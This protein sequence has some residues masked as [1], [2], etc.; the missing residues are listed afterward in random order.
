MNNVSFPALGIEDLAI[1]PVAFTIFGHEVMWYGIIITAA[2][3]LAVCYV[4]WR[5]RLEGVKK[6]DIYDL[7]IAV[8]FTG[9]VGARLYYVL[10]KGGY[11]SFMDIIAIWKGGLAIYGGIIGGVLA[12]YVYSKIKKIRFTKIL[13]MIGPATMI[14]QAL[15]RWGNFFNQEAFGT[16][17]TLPWGMYSDRT[18]SY[19]FSHQEELF[20]AGIEVDPTMPVHP[21]FLYE[22]IWNVLGF[23]IINLLYK[24]KK[25]NG[26]IFLMYISW[27]G[28][29][30]ML[31]EGLRTDSL[32]IFGSVRVSQLV[33]FLSFAI[34]IVAIFYMLR[35]TKSKK[36][37]PFSQPAYYGVKAKT[38][39][40]V[41][42]AEE[43]EKNAEEAS[44]DNAPEAS[45]QSEDSTQTTENQGE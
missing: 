16:N 30:R 24:K 37:S 28:F 2:M 7:A 9:I 34:G 10:T 12:A 20:A 22:S 32:Y 3:I 15:G 6:D 5:S 19:L 40:A 31:I 25:F 45:S 14:A 8:I 1:N 43:T 4:L 44:A 33:G 39:E 18:F 17:T 13:D 41:P 11:T 27:Y 38:E 26:Q 29:G 23:V 35:K 36:I 21:T 42:T